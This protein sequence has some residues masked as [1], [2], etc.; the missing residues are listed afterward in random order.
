M[1]RKK[2]SVDG[3]SEELTRRKLKA[4]RHVNTKLST[5]TYMFF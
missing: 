4:I 3:S 1:S 2:E 5:V